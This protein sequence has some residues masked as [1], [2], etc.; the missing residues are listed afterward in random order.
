MS[1]TRNRY[2]FV[3]EMLGSQA[4]QLLF[5]WCIAIADVPDLDDLTNVEVS[6][7]HGVSPRD[8]NL[9]SG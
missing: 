4:H 6:Q 1:L 9:V 2:R 7:N 3:V 5:R 8:D